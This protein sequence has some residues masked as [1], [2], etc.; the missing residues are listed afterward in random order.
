M[1]LAPEP[2]LPERFIDVDTGWVMLRITPMH[3]TRLHGPWPKDLVRQ[4]DVAIKAGEA[5][6]LLPGASPVDMTLCPGMTPDELEMGTVFEPNSSLGDT[7]W[8]R[9]LAYIGTPFGWAN[10]ATPF[11]EEGRLVSLKINP[12]G[13]IYETGFERMAAYLLGVLGPPARDDKMKQWTFPWGEV[14]MYY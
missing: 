2:A 3:L 13:E 11:F 7:S 1:E 4:Q 8:Y 6:P 5:F 10:D 9:W 14:Q 12:P